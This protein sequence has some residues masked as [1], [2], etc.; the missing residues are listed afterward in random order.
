MPACHAGS[1]INKRMV[2]SDLKGGQSDLGWDLFGTG[3]L[4]CE[5]TLLSAKK[6]TVVQAWMMFEGKSKP[7]QD[8]KELHSL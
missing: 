4:L 1:W 7:K 6:P 3:K 5:R 2:I 8:Y